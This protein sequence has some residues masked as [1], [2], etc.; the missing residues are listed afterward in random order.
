[1]FS[2]VPG[3]AGGTDA[4]PSAIAWWR[5]DPGR[6]RAGQADPAAAAR[7]EIVLAG[8]RAAVASGV[9][10]DSA[11]SKALEGLL[12]AGEVG[13]TRHTLCL[14]DFEA[15]RG[16]GG[17]GMDPQ[18]L[19]MVLE[20]ESPSNRPAL[21]RTVRAILIGSG[22]G[23]AEAAGRQRIIKLPGGREGVAYSEADWPAWRQVAWASTEDAFVIGLGEGALEAW[24]A[25]PDPD[26]GTRPPWAAHR[27]AAARARQSDDVFFEA[28]LGLD[29]LRRGFPEAF[30]EGRA[31][32]VLAATN[33]S[34]ARDFMLHGRWAEPPADRRHPPMIALDATWSARSRAPGAVEHRRLSES[35]WPEE[36]IAMAPPPGSYVIAMPAPWREWVDTALR[37][38]PAAT[39]EE[40][41]VWRMVA[42]RQWR[43]AHG[44]NLRAFL[45]SLA[46]WL[47]VSDTPPPVLPMPGASTFFAELRADASP[48]DAAALLH[49]LLSP[50][51]EQILR[52]QGVWSFR[53]DEGGLLRIP[54]WG[55]IEAEPRAVMVGGWGPPV[56]IE[57]RRRLRETAA[58]R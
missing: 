31:E 25:A 8:F 55:F 7:R 41:H 24:F 19:Q 29:G 35:S 40:K 45:D 32:R 37:I 18:I 47:I 28:Y 44:D 48:D 6:F 38:V 43:R 46:P 57:N 27:E 39:P 12:A 13:S 3:A 17:T 42:V 9:V 49:S 11:A 51:R 50:F 2:G 22:P 14:L 36:E 52:D 53:V 26:V 10:E 15:Q 20:L 1:V 56:V 30:V 58:K 4:P 5:L 54:S 23:G 33:L 34:N 16:P 21:L